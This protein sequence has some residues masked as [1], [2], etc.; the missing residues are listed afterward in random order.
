MRDRLIELFYENNVRCNQTI[1][2]LIDDAM[3][4]F[5][6][7]LK[8]NCRKCKKDN[9]TCGMGLAYREGSLD[10]PNYQEKRQTN[11]D[12]IKT[13]SVEEMAEFLSDIANCCIW[14]DCEHCPLNLLA[15]NNECFMKEWLE[16][17]VQE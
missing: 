15:C 12:R 14:D 2:H 17:E 11:F 1:E 7:N 10:C 16:S 3:S 5:E 8:T 4:I 6:N 13:M 9:L